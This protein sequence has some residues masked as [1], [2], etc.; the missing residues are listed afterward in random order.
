MPLDRE[1][2]D[3][4][5]ELL[6]G[7]LTEVGDRPKPPLPDDEDTWLD[8]VAAVTDDV[9]GLDVAGWLCVVAALTIWGPRTDA[10]PAALATY[11]AETEGGD[12]GELTKV[13]TPVVER[14]H[15]LEVVD[16]VG[17]LTKL[18]WWGLPEAFIR[19]WS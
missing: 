12:H 16:D 13:F 3:E 19:A 18:G 17:R 5:A 4:A 2:L 7:I 14:W 1:G 6:K 15:A 11:V 8:Q 9:G 10:D